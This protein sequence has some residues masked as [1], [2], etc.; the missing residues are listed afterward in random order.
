[1]FKLGD[2]VKEIKKPIKEINPA[3]EAIS[4]VVLSHHTPYLVAMRH[5]Q[6]SLRA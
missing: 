5:L 4:R 6:T 3:R 2:M 1:M